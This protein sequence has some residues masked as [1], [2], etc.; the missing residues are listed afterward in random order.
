MDCSVYTQEVARAVS[1]VAPRP[2]LEDCQE[3]DMVLAPDLEEE[4]RPP[5]HWLDEEEFRYAEQLKPQP[6]QRLLPWQ[7]AFQVVVPA[8]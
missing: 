7:P 6:W 3:L 2:V 5:Q 4:F 8:D 1:L